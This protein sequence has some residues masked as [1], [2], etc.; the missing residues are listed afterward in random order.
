MSTAVRGRSLS[1][2]VVIGYDGRSSMSSL[3]SLAALRVQLA[4]PPLLARGG[5]RGRWPCGSRPTSGSAGHGGGAPARVPR[6]RRHLFELGYGA[7]RIGV[8]T[9]TNA[10]AGEA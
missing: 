8:F 2:G 7:V 3:S 10:L 5:L 1:R 9:P 4:K 6:G